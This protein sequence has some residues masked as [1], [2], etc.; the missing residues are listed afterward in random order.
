MV[1]P[2]GNLWFTEVGAN[3]IET[4]QANAPGE[5]RRRRRIF[6]G[7][8]ARRRVHRAIAAGLVAALCFANPRAG[9]ASCATP[10]F[11]PPLALPLAAGSAPDSV[12]VGDFNGD[13]HLDLAVVNAGPGTVSILLGGGTGSFGAATN[14]AV[15]SDPLSV[16]VGD[17]NGDGHLDLAVANW[18]SNSVS[19]LLGDGTGS[20]GAA[21]D[22][23]VDSTAG[24]KPRSVAVGD[25]NGDGHPDLALPISAPRGSGPDSVSILLGDGTGSFGVA[26]SF[27]VQNNA[28]PVAIG[29][30][31]D[32]GSLDLAVPN[33]LSGTVSILLGDGVGRFGPTSNFTVGS[34]PDAVAV[35]DFN[36]D[37]HLDLAVAYGSTTVSILLGDG[38]GRFGAA[39]D[40][41]VGN[42]ESLAVGDFNG[43]GH[44]DLATANA[45][46]ETVS[47]LLGNGTGSF[48]AATHFTVGSHPLF[49]GAVFVAVADFNDDGVLDLVTASSANNTVSILL[50]SCG[51]PTATPTPTAACVGD[52]DASSDVTV[53]E[54]ITLV[55]IDLGTADG[56]ACPHGIP[57]GSSVDIT[58]IIQAVNNDL[59][60]C[61]AP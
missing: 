38:T 16:R 21:T 27:P 35:G 33:S 55:N 1:G 11:N 28:F 34:S 19:I 53:N 9:R 25:F 56:S 2:D 15:G 39:T 20:F 49:G 48:G 32:D 57:S 37:G 29:D 3:K 54:I 24:S 47:V 6:V 58:L 52:C 13:G 36:G 7:T 14:F 42:A 43:D 59:V 61:P 30:F 45:G 10:Q 23:T 41:T 4:I 40:F 5:C 44:L 18:I 26:T 46:A 50:N 12:A 51:L 22:F 17:F 60:S 8:A 31:N